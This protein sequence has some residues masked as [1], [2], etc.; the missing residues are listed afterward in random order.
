[1]DRPLECA[2]CQKPLAIVY[3]EIKEGIIASCGLCNECP[4]LQKKLYKTP[5]ED[6]SL[7]T[8]TPMGVCCARCGTAQD[9]IMR[10]ELLGCPECYQHF[11]EPIINQLVS[12][13][14]LPSALRKSP[15]Q[16]RAPLHI[17]KTPKGTKTT[18][19]PTQ[20][21]SLIEALNEAIKK[22]NYEQAAWLRDQ[23]QSLKGKDHGREDKTP[24]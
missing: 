18:S 20:L 4:I 15:L 9:T 24:K 17:G 8:N 21:S 5:A 3:K 14:K 7:E 13:K 1:V 10:G 19:A 22:E 16:A 12:L 2:Q 23:I 6:L 11:R